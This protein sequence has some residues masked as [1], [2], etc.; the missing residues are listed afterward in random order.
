MQEQIK[1]IFF[2]DI[3]GKMGRKA[4]G[5]YLMEIRAQEF[6][7]DFAIANAENASHGFGLTEKNYKESDGRTSG[8]GERIPPPEN[9]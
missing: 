1:I 5:N 7:P 4:V 3:V 6:A 8:G 9:G 2:G